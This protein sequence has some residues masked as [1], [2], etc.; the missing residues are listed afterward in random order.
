MKKYLRSI[1]AFVLVLS[2]VIIPM[3]AKAAGNEFNI[4]IKENELNEE[5]AK[6]ILKALSKDEVK[7]DALDE[8]KEMNGDKE[9]RVMVE[10]KESPLISLAELKG[11]KVSELNKIQAQEKE[12]RILSSQN[13]VKK[14]IEAQGVKAEYLDQY[15]TILNGFSAKIKVSDIEKIRNIRGVEEVNISNEYYRPEPNMNT[16]NEQ[17]D[18]KLAWD[19]GYAGEKTVLAVIDTGV[20]PNH[21]DFVMRDGV[22]LSYTEEEMNDLINEEALPGKW[23]NDKVPYAYNYYDRNNIVYDTGSSQHGMHVGGTMAANGEVTGVAPDAQL[24]S[25]KVFSNDIRYAT[26]FSDIYIK[27]IDDAI[28]LGADAVNLSLGSPAGFNRENSMEEKVLRRAR[29]NG[30]VPT[31]SAGNERNVVNGGQ[32]FGVPYTLK[33]NP[34]TALLGSPSANL[35]AFSVAS[36]ENTHLMSAVGYVPEIPEALE[37]DVKEALSLIPLNE[38]SGAPSFKTLAD[39]EYEYVFVNIGT[40]DDFDKVDVEGKIAIAERGNSFADTIVNGMNAKAAGVLVYNHESGGEAIVNMAGGEGAT[41]PFAFLKRSSGLALKAALEA[42]ENVKIVFKANEE[43][44]ESPTA[45]EMST[46]SSWGPTPDLRLKPEILAPG[47]N[48]RSTQNNNGYT[49]MSG[50]SMAAPHVAGAVGVVKEYIR[51][52]VEKGVFEEMSPQE[53]ADI[54]QLILMNTGVIMSNPKYDYIYTP[55]EQGA[56][57]INL[58]KATS[59]LVLVTDNDKNNTSFGKGKL[60]LGEVGDS[61]DVTLLIRNY[62]EEDV[63]FTPKVTVIQEIEYQGMLVEITETLKEYELEKVLVPKRGSKEIK[64]NLDLANVSENRFAEGYVELLN[65]D[66]KDLSLPFLGFKG[67]WDEPRVLD[68]MDLTNFFALLLGS[69]MEVDKADNVNQPSEFKTSGFL[70]QGKYINVPDP[71]KLII[72]PQNF[73]Y[74]LLLGVGEVEPI[75]TQLRNAKEMSYEILDEDGNVLKTLLKEKDTRKLSRLDQGQLPLRFVDGS[76]FDGTVNG[77]FLPDGLYTYRIKSLVDY[78]TAKPQYDDFPLVIDNVGPDFI[79]DENGN[80]DYQ[81]DKETGELTFRA[82]DVLD[83][84][85]SIE[86]VA[87]LN[88]IFIYNYGN[89]ESYT[90]ELDKAILENEEKDIYKITLNLNDYI[91]IGEKQELDISL[92]DNI[93]NQSKDAIAI[94]D[95]DNDDFVVDDKTIPNI[96]VDKPELLEVYP[97]LSNPEEG[98]KYDGMDKIEIAVHGYVWGWNKLDHVLANGEEI[99][100]EKVEEIDLSEDESVKYKGPG[101]EFNGTIELGE[102]YHSI[103]VEA[104]AEYKEDF[105]I[106]RSFFV[107]LTKPTV[108]G[109]EIFKTEDDSFIVKFKL[110]DNLHYL[111]VMKNDDFL[112]EIDMSME[113]GFEADIKDYEFENE[114]KNL[115]DGINKVTYTI[116]DYVYTID[117][118]VY[119]L[120]NTDVNI[121]NLLAAIKEA[122]EVDT[123]LYV[124]NKVEALLEAYENALEVLDTPESSQEDIDNAEKLLREALE[125]LKMPASDEELAPLIEEL[126]K[127]EELDLDLYTDETRKELEDAINK[128]NEVLDKEEPTSEEVAEAL[129]MLRKA[130]DALEFK[131]VFEGKDVNIYVGEE[132]DLSEVFIAKDKKG[133]DVEVTIEEGQVDRFKVGEYEVVAKATIDGEE[134]TASIKVNVLENDKEELKLAI[135]KANEVDLEAYNYSDESVEKLNMALE[136][137]EEVLSNVNALKDEIKEA[138]DKLNEAVKGLEI[139][140]TPIEDVVPTIEAKDQVVKVKSKVNLNKFFKAKDKNG[141]ALAVEISGEFDENQVGI[142]EITGEVKFNG[143][144]NKKT[145]KVEVVEND[146]EALADMLERSKQFGLSLYTEETAKVLEEKIAIAEKVYEDENA[147]EKEILDALQDLVDACLKLEFKPLVNKGILNTLIKKADSINLE[148]YTEESIKVF[149]DALNKAKVVQANMLAS[150]DEV[151]KAVLSLNEAIN[152]LEIVH[153][154][155]WAM[156]D[157]SWYYY[158]NNEKIVDKW[159]WAELD[160]DNDGEADVDANG[161]KRGNWKYFDKEGKN[162][163]L[164]YIDGN[165]WLSQV[166]PHKEYL[167]GWWQNEAGMTYYFRESSGTRVEGWQ[168]IDGSWRY[169][170]KSGT[171]VSGRQWI[172]GKWH[173]FSDD[174]R[175]I[176]TR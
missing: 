96:Y 43:S 121:E 66:G 80:I 85:S 122:E 15:T 165:I 32:A 95:E 94:N 8:I 161:K 136:K 78:P 173:T 74:N 53:E 23:Y 86:K 132:L 55:R 47:G 79:R 27:A 169:F 138:T 20:D 152:N 91:D 160:L 33:E 89:D 2:M 102:G 151:D 7:K 164:F 111:R 1:I 145:I 146:K 67:K 11:V 19:S 42:D 63:E 162:I 137:A 51:D 171:L 62:G 70:Q 28:K 149:K 81:L 82:T 112:E 58:G 52:Q 36:F 24:I 108:D 172:D 154:E 101:F 14:A 71:D 26:T 110:N 174:G 148:D 105:S 123:S 129:D 56:G 54:A 99:P 50:T 22:E 77:E 128:A 87:G 131:P 140:W 115:V 119:I 142:Y 45:N 38:A 109:E 76:S 98:D 166:G 156:E 4:T 90:F 100:F 65:E 127:A 25:M 116:N 92:V 147:S 125:A 17:I 144:V 150:Q 48:I 158:K 134:L 106:G 13:A 120:K 83:E 37:E 21:K 139:V 155:G 153:K 73:L 124:D 114:V 40:K 39:K 31:I 41:V 168:Y 3:P 135:S 157:G 10:L 133:E 104:K 64:V 44:V 9:V 130:M 69:P 49:T 5:R 103:L 18:S 34:D 12:K 61:K 35:S 93:Y 16:S 75:I 107:D 159:I 30:I 143:A 59:N 126:N 72:A 117:H 6:A 163:E 167:K 118:T 175:L 68:S 84:N 170:R 46:F 176:G 60:E 97:K 57:L 141:N 88:S 29:E 113:D